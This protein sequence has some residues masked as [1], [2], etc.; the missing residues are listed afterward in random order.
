M[1]CLPA[2]GR[3]CN[4][5]GQIWQLAHSAELASGHSIFGRFPWLPGSSCS[6]KGV[7]QTLVIRLK[8]Q[9][10]ES[11]RLEQ[12]GAMLP[13]ILYWQSSRLSVTC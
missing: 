7:L 11:C 4:K 1:V 12:R 2:V 5:G 9:M 3:L 10:L 8:T 6:R 13:T